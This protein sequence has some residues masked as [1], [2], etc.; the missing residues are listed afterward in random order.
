M[1]GLA[2][3]GDERAVEPLLR[4]LGAAGGGADD[5]L[6]TRHALEEATIRLAALTGDARFAPYLPQDVERFAGTTLEEELRRA[7]D[8]CGVVAAPVQRRGPKIGRVATGP[9]PARCF[10]DRTPYRGLIAKASRAPPWKRFHR[11]RHGRPNPPPQCRR[12]GAYLATE[13]S[14]SGDGAG[15]IVTTAA[16]ASTAPGS[17]GA[18]SSVKAWASA[19]GGPSAWRGVGVAVAVGVAVGV[20]VGEGVGGRG[21][22][23]RRGDG[24]AAGVGAARSTR[25]ARGPG[26]APAARA[27]SVVRRRRRRRRGRRDGRMACG[28]GGVE[29]AADLVEVREAIVVVVLGAVRNAVAV[30]VRQRAGRA[31]AS[32]RRR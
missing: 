1:H 4:R 19:L 11:G 14:A 28:V 5:P 6:W 22:R 8:R 30:G 24:S 21:R 27:G 2:L 12:S 15:V 10:R 18:R 13:S 32:A 20:G 23:R 26:S 31:P 17:A 25:T 9:V 3:R 7:L 29:A 16:A